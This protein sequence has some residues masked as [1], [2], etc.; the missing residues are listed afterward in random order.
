MNLNISL[1]DAKV[2][3]AVANIES[4]IGKPNLVIDIKVVPKGVMTNR[5]YL[6]RNL[7]Y[8][9]K[10]ILQKADDFKKDKDYTD[11]IKSIPQPVKVKLPSNIVDIV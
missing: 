8:L 10:E 9:I 5:E 1:D 11:Q 4:L 6:K 2:S 3:E 7:A